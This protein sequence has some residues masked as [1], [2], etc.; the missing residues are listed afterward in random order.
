MRHLFLSYILAVAALASAQQPDALTRL[1][2]EPKLQ[3]RFTKD[4]PA[5]TIRDFLG[6]ISKETGVT[7]KAG[8][9]TAGDMVIL[10]IR[11]QTYADVLK[12]LAEH[13]DFTWETRGAEYLLMQSNEAVQRETKL[14]TEEENRLVAEVKKEVAKEATLSSEEVAKMKE[15]VMAWLQKEPKIDWEAVGKK[16]EQQ[17]ENY[18]DLPEEREY[19][20]WQ[21][22]PEGR[23]TGRLAPDR[24]MLAK[25]ALGLS[26]KV[27]RSLLNGDS[28]TFCTAP[29]ANQY[30]L[31]PQWLA[32]VRQWL[33]EPPDVGG[34]SPNESL[35]YK[36]QNMIRPNLNPIF[37]RPLAPTGQV[38]PDSVAAVSLM[39]SYTGPTAMFRR[40]MD[41]SLAITLIA[42]DPARKPIYQLAQAFPSP[43]AQS[44][45]IG[46]DATEAPEQPLKD[47]SKDPLLGKKVK[48]PR[49][50]RLNSSDEAEQMKAF[51]DMMTNM[52]TKDP[53]NWSKAPIRLALADAMGMSL[54]ADGYDDGLDAFNIFT[55]GLGNA[56]APV[57][58]D[59]VGQ[60]L[61]NFKQESD[62]EYTIKDGWVALRT[63][64]WAYERPRQMPRPFIFELMAASTGK[65]DLSM[66]KLCSLAIGA[67]ELQYRSH[68]GSFDMPF[69]IGPQSGL[70]SAST[71]SLLRFWGATSIA[72]RNQFITG[73]PIPLQMLS[74]LQRDHI[75]HAVR[76]R[77]GGFGRGWSM[78]DFGDYDPFRREAEK[79]AWQKPPQPYDWTEYVPESTPM[80]LAV[81]LQFK[82]SNGFYMDIANKDSGGSMMKMSIEPYMMSSMMEM[83]PE[84]RDR[85]EQAGMIP[86][87]GREV[88]ESYT[89]YIHLTDKIASTV[90]I[91]VN[92]RLPG[93]EFDPAHPPEDVLQIIK[94]EKEKRKKM[95]EQPGDIPVPVEEPG[96]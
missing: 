19:Q 34:E 92:H 86:K 17:G 40:E 3:A 85:A 18:E 1:A 79:S 35:D 23:M 91:R 68:T 28:V 71:R 4:F 31:P 7:L 47:Y 66:D 15:K 64:N 6:A 55:I 70:S 41:A 39:L 53:L 77:A 65:N 76:Q 96:G 30:P 61:D 9:R 62:Q 82:Q 74:P 44:L 75:L 27:W 29:R 60:V 22:L 59:Q 83:R 36:F 49:D 50:N 72:Q 20:G 43:E 90:R 38:S 5:T 88:V 42:M 37:E 80:P 2:S 93:S 12:R 95:E 26:D 69:S 58:G 57:V 14:R 52:A 32:T 46:T 81:S 25:F 16:H 48:L 8:A 94:E 67:T 10:S 33:A 73:R 89:F 51:M 56:G 78:E 21:S 54:I 63:R 87:M 84:E 24:P 45:G 11:D 13:F